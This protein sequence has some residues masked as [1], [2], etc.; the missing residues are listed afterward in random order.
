MGR[1]NKNSQLQAIRTKR[2]HTLF[3]LNYIYTKAAF[4]ATTVP[5]LNY[6]AQEQIEPTVEC[7]FQF[8]EKSPNLQYQ[9]RFRALLS[10]NI[11]C[12]VKRNGIRLNND[13]ISNGGSALFFPAAFAMK[14]TWY[15]DYYHYKYLNGKFTPL[16]EEMEPESP[17][18]E[19]FLFQLDPKIVTETK[20]RPNVKKYPIKHPGENVKFGVYKTKYAHLTESRTKTDNHEGGDFIQENA[21]GRVIPFLKRGQI[22][23]QQNF[24]D[25]VRRCQLSRDG[26]TKKENETESKRK[27]PKY[28]NEVQAVAALILHKNENPLNPEEIGDLHE[29]VMNISQIGKEN[30]RTFFKNRILAI[31]TGCIKFKP[32]FITK[33]SYSEYQKIENQSKK[34]ISEKILE[35]ISKITFE[36]PQEKTYFENKAV[37]MTIKKTELIEIYTELSQML[38]LEDVDED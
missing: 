38:V 3:E 35:I 10:L 11:P 24:A 16:E 17:D 37:K 18:F 12:I 31:P 9:A 23:S 34:V 36:D 22:F 32:A 14:M 13:E 1:H 7:L 27:R 20:T 6:C 29:D 25:A 5:F 30:Y 19:K 15:R 33:K 26:Q 8:V 4:T 28:E 2:L 21:L